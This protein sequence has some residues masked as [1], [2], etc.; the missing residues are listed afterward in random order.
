MKTGRPA[1][2]P[3][4]LHPAVP[5]EAGIK[6]NKET[7]GRAVSRFIEVGERTRCPAETPPTG[8]LVLKVTPETERG[9]MEATGGLVQM[10][11]T[12]LLG[13]LCPVAPA[14]EGAEPAE[15]LRCESRGPRVRP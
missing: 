15:G 4:S 7:S 5:A 12:S 9:D 11:E 8:T 13:P 6:G 2:D 14:G 1:R 3:R 10:E